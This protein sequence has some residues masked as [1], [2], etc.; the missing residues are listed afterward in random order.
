MKKMENTSQLWFVRV[1]LNPSIQLV[2]TLQ[3]APSTAAVRVTGDQKLHGHLQCAKEH[4][5]DE[6]PVVGAEQRPAA[7]EHGAGHPAECEQ[8]R[9]DGLGGLFDGRRTDELPESGVKVRIL[10]FFV[11]V[12][13]F[14]PTTESRAKSK[15][16]TP[17]R[18]PPSPSRSML[19]N[20]RRAVCIYWEHEPVPSSRETTAP[21]GSTFN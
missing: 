5:C 18:T 19:Y 17:D 11:A 20:G 21:P 1:K 12:A 7:E 16:P 2:L 14:M 8:Q 4:D 10:S 13:L 3:L 6:R 15:E 9:R